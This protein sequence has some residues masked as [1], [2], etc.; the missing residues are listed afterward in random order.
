MKEQNGKGTSG[1]QRDESRVQR[2]RREMDETIEIANGI[3]RM[4]KRGE[5]ESESQVE[6][7]DASQE[8]RSEDTT[9]TS[10]DE[11]SEYR[12]RSSTVVLHHD[13]SS[14]D[15][16]AEISPSEAQEAQVAAYR[17][18]Y[19]VTNDQDF[20]WAFEDFGQACRIAGKAVAVAWSKIRDGREPHPDTIAASKQEQFE[21]FQNA[22]DMRERR[23]KINEQEFPGE[24]RPRKRMYASSPG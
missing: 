5:E 4:L 10:D 15:L 14:E 11:M 6:R 13:S 8:E 1:A 21:F 17:I 23:R 7:S 20:V 19:T 9:P 12:L 24:R 2:N 18:K 16:G 3:T 22:I